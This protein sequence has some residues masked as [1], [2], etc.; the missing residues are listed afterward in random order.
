MDNLSHSVVGLATGEFIHRSLRQESDI[1]H[2]RARRSLLLISCWAASNFP[3][4][5]IFFTQLLPAP[6]GYLLHHRGHTH[7]LLYIIPQAILLWVVI[8]LC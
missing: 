7:T 6:L 4:L 1:N 3:D 2:Q 8:W 5:D